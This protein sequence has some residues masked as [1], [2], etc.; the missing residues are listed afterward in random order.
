[1]SKFY[2]HNSLVVILFIIFEGHIVNL[3]IPIDRAR[4]SGHWDVNNTGNQS[5]ILPHHFIKPFGNLLEFFMADFKR[6]VYR[7]F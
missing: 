3:T 2:A 6:V 1:M 7:P 5:L 4:E